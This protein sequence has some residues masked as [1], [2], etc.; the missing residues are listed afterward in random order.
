MVKYSYLNINS[1]YFLFSKHAKVSSEVTTL[2]P[3]DIQ[4]VIVGQVHK[5]T[6]NPPTTYIS[7]VTEVSYPFKL[8]P[9]YVDAW[10]LI[11]SGTNNN[12]TTTTITDADLSSSGYPN[13]YADVPGSYSS[14]SWQVQVVP[15]PGACDV[16]G[17][18]TGANVFQITCVDLTSTNC[19]PISTGVSMTLDI[20]SENFCDQVVTDI[21]AV[22]S[23]VCTD[24]N[25][26]YTSTPLIVGPGEQAYF[27]IAL[28]NSSSGVSVTK[29]TL[30]R[31]FVSTPNMFPTNPFPIL[32]SNITELGF[33]IDES[34]MDLE[35]YFTFDM[36]DNSIFQVAPATENQL[37]MAVRVN[38]EYRGISEKSS[39][40]VDNSPLS[41]AAD[42]S[43]IVSVTT[44]S[45][46][47]VVSP[48]GSSCI[49]LF[50]AIILF[51]E[52]TQV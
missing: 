38:I 11:P 24:N 36:S 47:N 43:T 32:L 5:N 27:K 31:V 19:P 34:T 29:L 9:F 37:S 17:V 39:N 42:I 1:Q 41:T 35:I 44:L 14:Q 12:G 8:E 7:I 46:A 40:S 25:Y 50:L 15:G 45:S 21:G 16:D 52:L 10:T 20:T 49:I 3:I 18:Y 22:L 2:A 51:M 33:E 30:D 13:T 26:N 28:L 6:V 48:L 23:L 4:Q